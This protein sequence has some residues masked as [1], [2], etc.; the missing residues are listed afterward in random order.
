MRYSLLIC[1]TALFSTCIEEWCM[2]VSIGCCLNQETLIFCGPPLLSSAI[3]SGWMHY[4]HIL[5]TCVKSAISSSSVKSL[6]IWII[7]RIL[8]TGLPCQFSWTVRPTSSFLELKQRGLLHCIYEYLRCDYIRRIQQSFSKFG[9]KFVTERY[10]SVEY[11]RCEQRLVVNESIDE[12]CV[13]NRKFLK[14]TGILSYFRFTTV[15]TA[16]TC[17]ILPHYKLVLWNFVIDLH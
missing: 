10:E 11:L 5:S 8:W 15:K 6:A 9:M 17:S 4:N 16:P 14:I 1:Q 12:W 7:L 3:C 13:V 2:I